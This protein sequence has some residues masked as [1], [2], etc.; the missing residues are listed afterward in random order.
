MAST[1]GNITLIH[2]LI[3]DI[4]FIGLK[5]YPH[6]TIQAIINSNSIYQWNEEFSVYVAAN[7]KE[8]F[9]AIFNHFKGKAWINGSKFFEGK[10]RLKVNEKINLDQYRKRN[11]NKGRTVPTSYLAKLEY[12]G[13]SINTARTYIS[14]FEKFINTF[15]DRPLLEI[16]ENEIQEYLNAKA[17]KGASTSHLN[18]ILN[19][20]KFYYE[21]VEK[22]PNRF[23]SIDRPIKEETLPKVLS[24][25]SVKKMLLMT[26]NIKHKC[27]LSLLYSAGLR[28][29]ELINLTLS[30]I[31]SKR[32]VINVRQGKG[33]KDRNTILSPQ[34]LNDL[35][36]YFRE[37]K[38]KHYLFEG[39]NGAKYSG[40]S[41]AKI[42]DQARIRA[43]IREK[44]T[45]HMLRHSFATHLLENGTDLRYIQVLLGHSS[46]KTTEIYTK[47]SFS[48]IQNIKSPLDSLN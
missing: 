33:H 10:K 32:M 30:D 39:P 48:S 24:P 19:S 20:I 18:Q 41:I 36:T 5:F 23:Y 28:R 47:V 29:Q 7:T 35:R 44:V 9:N 6:K 46:S 45:P 11:S 4:K 31:D 21:V 14:C 27:I 16:N 34:V 40:T 42:L 17:R 2:L 22:M 15:P 3:S 12:K 1:F 13:Y 43:G 25:L 37:Y 8:N 26:Q 38:P